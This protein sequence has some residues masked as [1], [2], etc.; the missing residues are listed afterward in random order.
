MNILGKIRALI[1]NRMTVSNDTGV[2]NS[3]PLIMEEYVLAYRQVVERFGFNSVPQAGRMQLVGWDLEYVDGPALANFI[4]QLLIRRLNDFIPDNDQPLILDC[5][6]NIGF[7]VLNYKRQFPK[8]RVIAFEPDP[9]FAPVLR[10]NLKR[11][12]A[13]DV[14][15]VE[16]AVWIENGEMPWFSEGIDGSKLLVNPETADASLKVRT[17]DLKDYLTEPVDLLKI[18]IEGAEYKALDHIK[19][20]LDNVKNVIVECHVDQTNLAELGQTINILT[21]AGFHVTM[22]SMGVWRDLIRQKPVE[23]FHWEQYFAVSAWRTRLPEPPLMDDAIL[24]YAGIH[25]FLKLEDVIQRNMQECEEELLSVIRVLMS[26]QGVRSYT[27]KPPFKKTGNLGW[28]AVLPRVIPEGDNDQKRGEAM[29]LLFE[30][31]LLLGPSHSIHDDIRRFG[32]GRHSHWKSNLYFSSSDG[33]DP[34]KNGRIY[35]IIY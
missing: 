32:K 4:D 17:V 27:L 29:L 25:H 5:G 35:K 30:D 13:G 16:A 6:A 9:L 33:S 8:A 2:Q 15:V 28:V 24:P 22:N 12:N 11:N 10:N 18:D 26:Q 31:E 23:K 20:S 3:T 19:N 34:N 1:A 21:Q 14:Q 7:S